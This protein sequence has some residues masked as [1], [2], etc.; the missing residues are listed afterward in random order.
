M[1]LKSTYYGLT[2]CTKSKKSNEALLRYFCKMRFSGRFWPF[3]PSTCRTR[4][5]GNMT[6][7][8]LRRSYYDLISCTKSKK[9]NEVFLRYFPKTRFSGQ[10]WPFGPDSTATRIF[11]KILLQLSP[12]SLWSFITMQNFKKVEWAVPEIWDGTNERTDGTEFIGP[13]SATPGV[14]K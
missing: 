10:F 9:Y 11:L 12:N 1:H 6:Y 4:I 14:Q 7:M 13:R 5:F 8:Q 2:S 3:D